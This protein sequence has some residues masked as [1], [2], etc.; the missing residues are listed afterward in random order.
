MDRITEIVNLINQSLQEIVGVTDNLF[1]PEI[2]LYDYDGAKYSEHQNRK[3]TL[4]DKYVF[5]IYH[6]VGDINREERDDYSF[7]R[8]RVYDYVYSMTCTV[9]MYKI[10][11]QY[12]ALENL[13]YAF[14]QR[15]KTSNHEY[16]EI[17]VQSVDTDHD[18]INQREF[19]ATYDKHK[20]RFD[21]FQINYE[22]RLNNC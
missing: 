21:L 16:V 6:R 4:D 8:S 9:V 3:I 20:T 1:L 11:D 19:D 10:A 18:E 15:V 13:V 17:E 2:K 12:N 5:T 14:P 22:I 7:G